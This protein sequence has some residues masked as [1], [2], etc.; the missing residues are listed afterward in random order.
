[1]KIACL[2]W[3]SLIWDRRDLNICSEWYEDGPSLPI[4]FARES[5]DGRMTLVLTKETKES[6]SLWAILEESDIE[7]AKANLAKREGIADKNIRYSVGYWDSNSGEFHGCC[8]K[9]IS[10]WAMRKELDGV[11]WTNLKYGFRSG[12][13]TLPTI[14]EVFDHFDSLSSEKK[15][16][17]EQYV[18]K[19]PVQ[20]RTAF[21]EKLEEKLDWFPEI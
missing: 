4:E 12:R 3:G 10:E 8:S 6:T 7:T 14:K 16:K 19:T 1:M 5:T 9:Q 21:R 20:V 13:D 2:G 11:V 18:R 15:L 17:A